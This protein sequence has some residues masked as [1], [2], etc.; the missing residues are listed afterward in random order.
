MSLRAVAGVGSPRPLEAESAR[1]RVWDLPVRL[2]HWAVAAL[3]LFS[4]V[5]AEIDQL[6]WHKLS[7]Y[8]ILGLVVFRIYWGFVGGQTARFVSFV[9]GPRTFWHYAKS[10]FERQGER[11]LGHNPMGGWS[12]V[13]LLS[14]L[15]IQC[16][17]GLF[18]TDVDGIESGPLDDLVSFHTGRLIAHLH[19]VVFNLL[20]ALVGL[21]LAA[22]LFYALHKREDLIGAMLHGYKR[23]LPDDADRPSFVG[24]GRAIAGLLLAGLVVLAVTTRFRF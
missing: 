3:F 24:S 22:I 16:G 10:V 17:L 11:L 7:G 19:G 15:L 18:A 14:L 2:V 12:V 9:R 21:H 1:V 23:A 20:L 5:T 13:A 6:A 8:A 4:W